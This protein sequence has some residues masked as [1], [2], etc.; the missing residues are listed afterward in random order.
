[1]RLCL[2][3]INPARSCF[4]VV[5]LTISAVSNAF[6]AHYYMRSKKSVIFALMNGVAFPTLGSLVIVF[7]I[8]DSVRPMHL[9][10]H[11]FDH[12]YLLGDPRHC[13]HKSLIR[14]ASSSTGEKSPYRALT[15]S[16]R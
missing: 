13:S 15:R 6:R 4:T 8:R 10:G 2:P 3:E 7:Q 12:D 11:T 14:L 9:F 1:V 16:K 5:S